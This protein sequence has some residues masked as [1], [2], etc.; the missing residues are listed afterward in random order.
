MNKIK[1]RNNMIKVNWNALGKAMML[2][3]AILLGSFFG[4]LLVKYAPPVFT[5]VF[6]VVLMVG[7]FYWII[8][9]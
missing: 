5:S 7:F 8:K 9:D 3:G 2:T 4:M 6:M 1:L